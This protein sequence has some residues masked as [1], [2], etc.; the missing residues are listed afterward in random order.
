[1]TEQQPAAPGSTRAARD[2]Q[3][4]IPSDVLAIKI[5][6]VGGTVLALA[7]AAAIFVALVVLPGA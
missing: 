4:F 2:P 6:I 3:S 5:A 7:A 1:M